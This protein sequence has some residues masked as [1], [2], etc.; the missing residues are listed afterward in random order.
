M[1]DNK[2]LDAEL[3]DLTDAVLEGRTMTPKQ[4]LERLDEVVVQLHQTIAPDEPADPVFRRHLERRLVDEWNK[5]YRPAPRWYNRPRVRLVGA[6]AAMTFTLV[7]AAVLLYNLSGGQDELQGTATGPL[8]GQ[9]LVAL[10]LVTTVL[11]VVVLVAWYWWQ[12]RR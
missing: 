3:A 8:G 7:M 10:A 11:V 2:N 9:A 12:H 5:T 4:N 6:V 1:D